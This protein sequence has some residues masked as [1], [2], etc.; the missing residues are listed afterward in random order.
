MDFV[1]FVD[2]LVCY[3]DTHAR[4]H[5]HIKIIM[6]RFHIIISCFLVTILQTEHV[7]QICGKAYSRKDSLKR[8][9]QVHEE[10]EDL[11]CRVCERVFT[12][13]DNLI[14][15]ERNIHSRNDK[16]KDN[17]I[18]CDM[19]GK[20]CKTK[21]ALSDH[22]RLHTKK[23]VC[24]VCNARFTLKFQL[25]RH[26]ASH[27]QEKQQCSKCGK[28]FMQ[29]KEHMKRCTCTSEEGRQIFTCN[30]CNKSFKERRYLNQHNKNVHNSTLY[31]CKH[32]PT[33]FRYRSTRLLHIRKEHPELN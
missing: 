13:K 33:S 9:F 1:Q 4:A 32:C 11:Q 29:L 15:H 16:S 26:I 18:I 27:Y 10:R 24:Y 2:I 31:D 22:M 14:A 5:T 6:K 17:I 12:R 3:C 8:H 30:S 20:Q 19:C 23:H 21:K 7:C 25:Q 28:Y